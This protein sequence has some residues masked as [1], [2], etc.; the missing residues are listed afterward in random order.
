MHPTSHDL[1]KA[2]RAAM[3]ALLNANLATTLDLALQA[4]YAH[5]NVKGPSFIALHELFDQV[6]AAAMTMADTM[7][8]RVTAL[9]GTAGGTAR[10]VA[11]SSALKEYRLKAAGGAEH[12]KA[13]AAAIAGLAKPVRNAIDV[14]AQAGDAGTSDLFTAASREL[15]KL[16]WL[17]EAHG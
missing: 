17:V 1:P 10:I 2:A 6:H 8:E 13:L 15:D 4:K 9:G 12:V 16:L 7:A 14:A 5:W 11:A 3:V